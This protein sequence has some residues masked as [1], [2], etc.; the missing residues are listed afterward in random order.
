ML[1]LKYSSIQVLLTLV[2]LGALEEFKKIAIACQTRSLFLG[3]REEEGSK[4]KSALKV[5]LTSASK[6]P[7]PAISN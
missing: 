1:H 7:R 5:N 4:W 3:R 2:S 6:A